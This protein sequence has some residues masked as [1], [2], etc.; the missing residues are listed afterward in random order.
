VI[1][2]AHAILNDSGDEICHFNISLVA[3]SEHRVK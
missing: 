3:M 1:Y 2:V